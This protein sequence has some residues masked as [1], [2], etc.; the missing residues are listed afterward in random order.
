MLQGLY[1]EK[2]GSI[3]YFRRI[4][5]CSLNHKNHYMPHSKEKA[6]V[7]IKSKNK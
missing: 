7:Q 3:L 4:S 5:V 6:K 1:A 2:Y